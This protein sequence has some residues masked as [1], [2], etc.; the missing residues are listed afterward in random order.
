M[1]CYDRPTV[2]WGWVIVYALCCA[3]GLVLLALRMKGLL[4]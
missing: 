2:M 1:P 4:P 3:G